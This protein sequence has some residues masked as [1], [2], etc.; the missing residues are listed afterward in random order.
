MTL[1][2][3]ERE[4]EFLRMMD[5]TGILVAVVEATLIQDLGLDQDH[6]GDAKGPGVTPAH[7]CG[8]DHHPGPTPDPDPGHQSGRDLTP[9]KMLTRLLNAQLL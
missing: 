5:M 7:P 9:M 8:R 3:V 4:L 6:Q 1:N 2:W